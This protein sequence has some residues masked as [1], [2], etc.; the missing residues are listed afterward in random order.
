MNSVMA[1]DSKGLPF[2]KTAWPGELGYLV[3]CDADVFRSME[4]RPVVLELAADSTAAE[5]KSINGWWTNGRIG[6]YV[7]REQS[8]KSTDWCRQI[9]CTW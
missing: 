9:C 5:R 2:E 7:W 4:E 1:D 6:I 8:M 3:G